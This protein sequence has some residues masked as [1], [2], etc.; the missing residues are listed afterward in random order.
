MVCMSFSQTMDSWKIVRLVPDILKHPITYCMITAHFLIP[1]PSPLH[2]DHVPEEDVWTFGPEEDE[3]GVP[4]EADPVQL[5]HTV[6][7]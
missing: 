3:H 7:C 4:Q 1:T 5:L 2:S 6:L